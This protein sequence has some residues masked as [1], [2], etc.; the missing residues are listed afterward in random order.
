MP[1]RIETA[2]ASEIS[3]AR[4]NDL[5]LEMLAWMIVPSPR[6]YAPRLDRAYNHMEGATTP[7]TEKAGCSELALSERRARA[8]TIARARNSARQL[9]QRPD[10]AH[11][12]GLIRRSNRHP[13]AVRALNRTGR[14]TPSPARSRAEPSLAP[15]LAQSN[16][17]R[18]PGA[19]R[20]RQLERQP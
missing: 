8:E 19:I 16:V 18:T 7:Q 6:G 9:G 4:R 3:S 5:L 1:Q 15:R 11:A 17:C 2:S 10:L 20:V 13:L 12:R 14:R